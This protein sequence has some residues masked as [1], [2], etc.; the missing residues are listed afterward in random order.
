[1]E[2]AQI[3]QLAATAADEKKAEDVVILDMRQ[4]TPIADYFVI[5]S[6]SSRMQVQAIA[7]FV[8]ERLAAAEV[9]LQ[10]REGADGAGWILLDYGM[11]VV[12]VFLDQ[13]RTYYDLERLWSDAPRV[14]GVVATQEMEP[15]TGP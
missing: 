8:Q 1:M 6:A 2:A 7:R 3:A 11:V 14:M 4:L 13:L 5:C 12:H 9:D 15:A 10:R